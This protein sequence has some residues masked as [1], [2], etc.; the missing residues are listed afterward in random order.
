MV[1]DDQQKDKILAAHFAVTNLSEAAAIFDAFVHRMYCEGKYDQLKRWW[2]DMDALPVIRAAE[3]HI[4]SR[5][6]ERE[7][8]SDPIERPYVG[9]NGD[10]QF[11]GKSIGEIY[12]YYRTV[13]PQEMQI[14][15]AY[16]SLIERFMGFLQRGKCA[17]RLS[18]NDLGSRIFVPR[19]NPNTEFDLVSEWNRF[20]K[21]AYSKAELYKSFTLFVNGLKLTNRGFG[22][23]R[24]P[25]AT[26]EM[27]NWLAAFYIATLRERVLR[28]ADNYKKA[29]SAFRKARDSV[30][31]YQD[32]LN[33][34][35]LTERRRASIE[36]KFGDE[37]QKMNDAIQDRRSA[38]KVN[39]EKLDQILS[40][41]RHQTDITRFDHAE[42]LSHRFNRTGSMQFSYGT[43]K[44]K[45][46]GGKSSIEDTIVEILNE[47]IA[48]L[49]CPFASLGEI[50]EALVRQAGDNTKNV[51]YSCGRLLPAKRK[52]QQANRFVLGDPSQRLQSGGSQ[53][54]PPVCGECLTVAFACPVKLT[55]RAIVVQLAPHDQTDESFSIE[56]HLRMLTLGELN[57]V[58]GRYLL[59]NCQ[60]FIGSGR[61][62]MLVSEKIGQVQ[63]T[64][65]RV[66]CTFPAAALHPMNLTL[67][68]G[69]TEILLK[70]R[71][72][73]W[74][75]LLN[76][77]FSPSLVVGQR[78]NIPLGQAIR[79]IQKDEVI[80]AIYRLV[81]AE[82][83][84]AKQLSDWSYREKRSLEELRE[85]H[86]DL[87]E[88]EQSSKGDKLMIK[89]AELYRDVAALTGLTHAYCDSIRWLLVDNREISDKQVQIEVKKLIEDATNPTGFIY[90]A[91]KELADKKYSETSA[92]MVR[93]DD[94]YFCY[95][96]AKYLLKNVLGLD[97]SKRKDYDKNGRESLRIYYDDILNAYTELSKGYDDIKWRKLSN[98]LKQNLY[99][100]FPFLFKKEANQDG[101]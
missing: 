14:K 95:D 19:T 25:P 42:E 77:I 16:D 80:S 33:S 65:W 86:C 54:Q 9:E 67:F 18:E 37:N 61:N 55:S 40:D 100:K 28:N 44:L 26:K 39:Q 4:R 7:P 12:S 46:Q 81:R 43:V 71:H 38:L 35:G 96:Q 11:M 69:G 50:S 52:H 31:R 62:P 49:S 2:D 72:F 83:T 101:N 87:L 17:I 48:A 13:L 99:A 84:A 24:F 63:Y 89:Q 22:Y 92:K 79:L 57:L 32:Q 82:S 3:H 88:D 70:T 45:S 41:L 20:I 74:L 15:I 78:D 59:I 53:T 6:S 27:A 94:N 34:N 51:C 29:D 23:V 36:M 47:S 93:R 58:A 8:S 90:R 97:I 30:K 98:Q 1:I 10:L 73:V 21:F 5:T 56:N 75:S 91:A 66:A 64:L 85:K 76:E 68:T 60:E